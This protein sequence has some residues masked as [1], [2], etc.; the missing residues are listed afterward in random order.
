MENILLAKDVA[1]WLNID[2]QRVYQLT[3]EGK[4]P[5][6]RLGDRQYRYLESQIE[7]WLE[8]GGNKNTAPS[9]DN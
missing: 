1:K 3:R 8:S 5:H 7:S 9:R 6:I 4:L 2:V